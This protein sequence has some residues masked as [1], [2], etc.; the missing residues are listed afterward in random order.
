M[1]YLQDP[2]AIYAQSF[3]TIRQE[4]DFSKL[5]TDIAAIAERMIHASG[6]V[7]LLDDLAFSHDVARAASAALAGG[8]PVIADCEMVR[9]GIIGA[10]LL[11]ETAVLCF[12]NDARVPV[13]ARE[14]KT[15]RSAAQTA[16]WQP[17]LAGSVVVIGNAPTALFALLEAIDRGGPK[18]AAIVAAPVGFVGA[19]ESKAEL[20]GHP[21]GIPFLTLQGRRGG[22]A[23]AASALNAIAKGLHD[24]VAA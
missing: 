6:M 10:F 7:D 24:K 9:S 19:A 5:P 14:R 17:H 15:T 20:A 12:L 16:L 2:A 4:V 23:M 22:S 21:R 11:P 18:P 8:Y 3:A 1:D 13:L